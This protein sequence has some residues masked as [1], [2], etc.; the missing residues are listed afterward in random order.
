VQSAKI[1]SNTTASLSVDEFSNASSTSDPTTRVFQL[2]AMEYYGDSELGVGMVGSV[3]FRTSL[4]GEKLQCTCTTQTEACQA[5][6]AFEFG[7]STSNSISNVCDASFNVYTYIRQPTLDYHIEL[8]CSDV[9]MHLQ[10]IFVQVTSGLE[11]S[12]PLEVHRRIVTEWKVRDKSMT[13]WSTI[14]PDVVDAF[15]SCP[16]CDGHMYGCEPVPT[17]CPHCHVCKPGSSLSSTGCGEDGVGTCELDNSEAVGNTKVH[18]HEYEE[19]VAGKDSI[20][21][22]RTFQLTPMDY[23]WDS[24]MGYGMVGQVELRVSEKG[25][26]QHKLNCE[27]RTLT[28]P[29]ENK[30]LFED[31]VCAPWAEGER[32]YYT[33]RRDSTLAYHFRFVCK[34]VPAMATDI[35]IYIHDGLAPEHWDSLKETDEMV[36]RHVT[37]WKVRDTSMG[38]WSLIRPRKRELFSSCPYCAHY[39]FGCDKAAPVGCA[40]CTVCATGKFLQDTSCAGTDANP[41]ICLDEDT[42]AKAA[43]CMEFTCPAGYTDKLTK[44][45]TSCQS[46]TC[47]A[48]KD[49]HRCCDP[50]TCET[51]A[52]CSAGYVKDPTSLAIA[53]GTKCNDQ[54]CCV[55]TCTALKTCINP[56]LEKNPSAD[57][58]YCPL[59][60]CSTFDR[61]AQGG[62]DS[63]GAP[64][65][66]VACDGDAVCCRPRAL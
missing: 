33:F 48:E 26:E 11:A 59:D 17:H 29:V 28:Q 53:C 18:G 24:K 56:A 50:W 2:R 64:C 51:Q 39:A 15:T 16:P 27:C 61:A 65:L 37:L 23:A 49:A 36:A 1:H 5:S 66:Q 4:T 25:I 60:H 57:D 35:D 58:V 41:G 31:S 46:A 44:G 12:S 13:A 7:C 6:Q 34:D 62:G 45:T 21:S 14:L 42:G 9:P 38:V 3:S 19:P 47:T 43:S 32:K 20:V 55:R 30:H 63:D 52:T 8:T 40:P 10:E 54:F 22:E